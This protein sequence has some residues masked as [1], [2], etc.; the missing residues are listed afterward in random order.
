M[1]FVLSCIPGTTA[2]GLHAMIALKMHP[3]A[4]QLFQPRLSIIPIHYKMIMKIQNDQFSTGNKS[5]EA[6]LYV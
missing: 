3:L 4:I 1:C 5:A 2:T 6:L